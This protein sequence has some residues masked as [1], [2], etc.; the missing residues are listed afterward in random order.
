MSVE[1]ANTLVRSGRVIVVV[2]LMVALTSACTAGGSGGA[3]DGAPGPSGTVQPSELR[4]A[5]RYRLPAEHAQWERL[6]QEDLE[7]LAITRQQQGM[8]S[9]PTDAVFVRFV[10]PDESAP[11]RAECLREQGFEATVEWDGGLSFGAQSA[12]QQPAMLAAEY[13]CQV[14]FPVHP[15]YSQRR[16]EAQIRVDYDYLVTELLPCLRAEGY[17]V[18]STAIPTWETF[19]ASYESKEGSWSPYQAVE[20]RRQEVTAASGGILPAEWFTEWR[21]I[22]EACPQGPPLDRLFPGAK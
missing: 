6:Y 9:P 22:N 11:V 2:S 19:L 17:D 15:K 7:E 14:K 16:T 20:K 12:D 13:R 8:P 1:A 21:R 10:N 5:A 18:D 3:G 4:F